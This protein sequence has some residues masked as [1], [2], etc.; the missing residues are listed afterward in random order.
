MGVQA[1]QQ[2]SHQ[3]ASVAS[4]PERPA[5]A[6]PSMT[7][8]AQASE[9]SEMGNDTSAAV[10]MDMHD[11]PDQQPAEVAARA[12]EVAP[13]AVSNIADSCSVQT[14]RVGAGVCEEADPAPAP[15]SGQAS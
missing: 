5:E 4:P 6:G 14:H 13:S 12:Q 9:L 7:A 3:G 15:Q 2:G 8:G 1:Q 11:T 10:P